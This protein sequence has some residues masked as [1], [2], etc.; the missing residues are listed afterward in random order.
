MSLS[1]GQ[2]KEVH[3]RLATEGGF[4]VNP[5]SGERVTKG[6]S[7]APFGNE[8]TV[9]SATSTPGDI[10]SYHAANTDRFGRGASLGGWRHEG[11]D[12]LDTPTVYPDTPGGV[13]RSRRQMLAS[14]QIASFN[15]SDFSEKFNPYH[16]ANRQGD[17]VAHD[18]PEQRDTWQKMPGRVGRVPKGRRIALRGQGQSFS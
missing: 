4:T 13:S 14:D 7:V 17:I 5:T 12:Y 16:A 3:Q 18:T 6:I 9:P 11:T 2:F 10:A 1:Q 8:R 15:L